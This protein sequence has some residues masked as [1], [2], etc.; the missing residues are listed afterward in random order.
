MY[1]KNSGI[2]E[3]K[4]TYC[5]YLSARTGFL[6]ATK[7]WKRKGTALSILIITRCRVWVIAEGRG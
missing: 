2:Y 5:Q 1:I 7:L 4:A 3:T 6:I